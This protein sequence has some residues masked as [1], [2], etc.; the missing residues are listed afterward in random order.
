MNIDQLNQWR[1]MLVLSRKIES[2]GNS[3]TTWVIET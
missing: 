2:K 3:W 1:M